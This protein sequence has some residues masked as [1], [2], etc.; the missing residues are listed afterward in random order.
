[1]RHESAGRGGS[2]CAAHRGISGSVAYLTRKSG[3][4]PAGQDVAQKSSTRVPVSAASG[5][6]PAATAPKPIPSCEQIARRLKR[7]YL[8]EARVPMPK[9]CYQNSV[10]PAA[11]NAF[12]EQSRTNF[13]HCNRS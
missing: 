7:F 3:D 11:P 8:A 9:S 10:P 12:G 13:C 5:K 1:V 4:S 6:Q 2:H